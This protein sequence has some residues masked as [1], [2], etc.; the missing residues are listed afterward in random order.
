LGSE[1]CDVARA[2][3]SKVFRSFASSFVE[4]A[5]ELNYDAQAPVGEPQEM[6]VRAA[7]EV[8]VRRWTNCELAVQR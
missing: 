7:A 3:A 2:G 5:L 6:K 4:I 1:E 8:F